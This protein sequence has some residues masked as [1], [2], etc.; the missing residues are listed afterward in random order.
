MHV[1]TA[2]APS[3][4]RDTVLATPAG[5]FPQATSTQPPTTPQPAT[6]P[7]RPEPAQT[8][9][10]GPLRSG[11]PR[12]NP[13]LAPRCGA[14]ART[15]GCCCRAPAMPNGRCRMHGGKSTGPRTTQGLANLASAHTTHG[16]YAQT[17]PD[18]E[19][20]EQIRHARVVSRRASLNGTAFSLLPWLPPAFSARLRADT[21]TELYAPNYNAWFH[22]VLAAPTPGPS[23]L[24]HT[25]ATPQ[26]ADHN[27]RPRRDAHGRFAPAPPRPLRGRQA[28]RARSRA[29][30][31]ELAP[32]KFAIVEARTAMRQTMRQD[33]AAQRQ[34]L[35]PGPTRQIPPAA[36]PGAGAPA[37]ATPPPAP[38]PNGD[39]THAQSAR[40]E[41]PRSN[42]M[43]RPAA[44]GPAGP[45]DGPD[46]IPMQR[47]TAAFPARPT[48][49][50]GE[51]S[52]KT[53]I[54]S[55]PPGTCPG[56]GTVPLSASSAPVASPGD[57]R[58]LAQSARIEISRTNP[59]NRPAASCPTGPADGPD[60]TPMQRGT[61]AGPTEPAGEA[62]AK[63]PIQSLP[64]GTCPGGGTVAP[65]TRPAG[66]ADAGANQH[67]IQRGAGRDPTAAATTPGPPAPTNPAPP[68]AAQP[69]PN[70]DRSDAIHPGTV[71]PGR[72][73]FRHA[74]LSSTATNTPEADKLATHAERAGGWPV[75][76]A[77]AAAKHA[78]QDWRPA[79]TAVRQ[80]L[81]DDANRHHAR[82]I[83]RLQPEADP[84]H[85]T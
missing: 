56:G 49:A 13:N 76:A 12:G 17:G 38:G 24:T 3:T 45:G 61:V 27:P 71:Q 23:T 59:M 35:K 5:Q 57:H 7:D 36:H 53:T 70:H 26:P 83:P 6:E 82:H 2:A 78:G 43:H 84:T 69:R 16:R 66:A 1:L 31:A 47:G 8:N 18:A 62:S 54:Q 42:P 34:S 4:V 64:S 44:S 29:E 40:I 22:A 75:M 11:N 14:K 10:T 25:T 30:A 9:R 81:I 85:T 65:P 20:R 68:L 55:L 51:A 32:W 48:E 39:G 33:Q 15:T 60:K 67:P 19:L 74:L 72:S 77:A 58:P 21:A 79:A 63:T 80:R 52:A 73:P 50:P 37:D 46:K 28:E 41:F